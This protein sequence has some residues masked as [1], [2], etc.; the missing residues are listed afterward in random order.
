MNG[1]KTCLQ[2][3]EHVSGNI[4]LRPNIGGKG[5][6]VGGHKHNFDHTTFIIRGSIHVKF[7]CPCQAT[8]RE[9]TYQ[10]GDHFL[11]K[12]EIEHFIE[13]LEDNSLFYCVYSHR[14]PTGEVV[15]EYPGIG[16]PHELSV[17]S[18]SAYQ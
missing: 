14:D 6:K 1:S 2:V 12:A 18:E 15:Q 7:G 8:Y 16:T 3:I 17:G 5:D 10:A 4:F 13:F 11:V 9:E